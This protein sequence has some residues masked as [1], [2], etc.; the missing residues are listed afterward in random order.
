M[1]HPEIM[2]KIFL[3]GTT[4]FPRHFC[5]K[6]FYKMVI[7]GRVHGAL[8]WQYFIDGYENAIILN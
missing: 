4:H 2:V 8:F 6:T 5:V 7:G 1:E 3:E